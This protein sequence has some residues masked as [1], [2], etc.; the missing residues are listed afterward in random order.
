MASTEL[1][2]VTQGLE[3]CGLFHA[4]NGGFFGTDSNVVWFLVFLKGGVKTW[5][6]LIGIG[7][8]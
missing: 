7:K 2:A 5:S 6:K 4:G 1:R 8:T 3:T